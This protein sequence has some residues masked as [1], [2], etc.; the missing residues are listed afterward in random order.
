MLPGL[1]CLEE[2][3]EEEEYEEEEERG[4]CWWAALVP[5]NNTA[6]TSTP[7]SSCMWMSGITLPTPAASPVYVITVAP[8]YTSSVYLS[9]Y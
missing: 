6:H 3:V 2:E 9:W 8:R 4:G 1:A 7:R 5:G